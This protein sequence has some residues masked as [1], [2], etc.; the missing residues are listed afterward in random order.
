VLHVRS[1]EPSLY[2][3][4]NLSRHYRREE[5]KRSFREAMK[6][7]HP[8]RGGDKAVFAK[9]KNLKAIMENPVNYYD[10]LNVTD[11][12]L[13][14]SNLPYDT[15]VSTK[16][17]TYVVETTI[18]YFIALLYSLAYTIE[19]DMRPARKF[20][21]LAIAAFAA[22]EAYLFHFPTTVTLIDVINDRVP[23]FLQNAVWKTTLS[24]LIAIIR[25]KFKRKLTKEKAL[26]QELR[27]QHS[28][29]EYRD[30]L[31]SLSELYF[32]RN[33]Q[34]AEGQKSWG[35]KLRRYIGNGFAVLV[36]I[37]MVRNLFLT[38]EREKPAEPS[39]ADF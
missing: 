12:D 5:F 26:L 24:L 22:Y 25:T 19:D 4:M 31:K 30:L 2:S 37:V 35:T 8:D 38:P 9:I 15:I 18:Y 29:T 10:L 13:R 39:H 21:L 11:A 3:Y 6:E 17:T 34:K 1:Q 20:I 33:M 16:K 36:M 14:Y 23:I 32:L 7:H 27:R 28:E